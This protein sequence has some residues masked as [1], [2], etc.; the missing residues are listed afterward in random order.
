MKIHYDGSITFDEWD[1]KFLKRFGIIEAAEMVVD[2]KTHN[3]LPFIYDTY[4]LAHHLELNRKMLFSAVRNCEKVYSKVIIKKQN[5]KDRVLQVPNWELKKIQGIILRC[6]V[7]KLPVSEY[8]TAYKKGARLID[9]ASPHTGKKYLLKMDI[10]DFFGSITFLQVYSSAFNTK[11]F[12]KQIGVMLTKLC[13]KD[14]H[15]P[16]GAPTSPAI[17]NLVMKKFDDNLGSWCEKRDISY[18]RYCDDLTFTSDK[19]MFSVYL[20]VKTMLEEMGF[21]IN[22]KKTH[23]ITDS[24]CQSVTGLTVNEKVSVSKEYKRTLRQE[25]H[26]ALKYGLADS[27]M[28]SDKVD[29]IE[30]HRPNTQKYYNHLMGKLNFVLQIEPDNK[31]FKEAR[32][33]MKSAEMLK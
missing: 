30:D 28:K 15:L 16:Q 29:F 21:E 14:G 5:G 26:Y 11:H 31:W 32:L 12:P 2:F 3:A 27:I 6:I 4:Q 24:A 10:T 19:P 20:K 9:N 7:T 22:S 33:K 13:T 18:T 17:S 25:L 1:M 23:F 8:A